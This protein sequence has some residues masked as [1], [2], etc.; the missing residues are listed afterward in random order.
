MLESYVTYKENL[1]QATTYNQIALSALTDVKSNLNKINNL[2]DLITNNQN[3]L[4]ETDIM[5]YKREVDSLC[6]LIDIIAKIT[7]YNNEIIL[8][9]MTAEKLKINNI[10]LF[11]IEEAKQIITNA[12]T[13]VDE[14]IEYYNNL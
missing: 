1:E 6:E 2:V 12:I 9:D 4:T 14:K 10:D 13:T 7:D 3:F 5:A 11:N 8:I